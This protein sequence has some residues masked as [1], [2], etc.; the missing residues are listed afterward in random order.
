MWTVT[1]DRPGASGEGASAMCAKLAA[2]SMLR[3]RFTM[4]RALTAS[5]AAAAA[6]VSLRAEPPAT[7]AVLTPEQT[8][9]RRGIADLEFSPDGTRLLFTVT[10]PV[11]GTARARSIW[12]LETSTAAA[13]QLTY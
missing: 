1:G 8:L 2:K 4:K 5:F 7:S 9:G 6:L 12:M 10:E 3:Y 13:R 11:K